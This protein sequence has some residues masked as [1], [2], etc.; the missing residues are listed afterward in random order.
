MELMGEVKLKFSQAEAV[1]EEP[2]YRTEIKKK[3]KVKCLKMNQAIGKKFGLNVGDTVLYTRLILMPGHK[4]TI[5][6]REKLAES[7]LDKPEQQV[8]V[9]DMSKC[10]IIFD[11]IDELSAWE[12]VDYDYTGE[13]NNVSEDSTVIEIMANIIRNNIANESSYMFT[14]RPIDSVNAANFDRSIRIFGFGKQEIEQCVSAICRNDTKTSQKVIDFIDRRPHL[15]LFCNIPIG[16]IMTGKVVL[17][18]VISSKR[19]GDFSMDVNCSTSLYILIVLVIL[20]SRQ[21]ERNILDKFQT[22]EENRGLLQQL[23]KLAKMNTIIDSPRLVFETEMLKQAGNDFSVLRSGFLD[24]ACADVDFLDNLGNHT[25][26]FIHY[27]IQEFLSAAYLVINWD[28]KDIT[29]VTMLRNANAFDSVLLFTAGLLGNNLG[30]KF[31]MRIDNSQTPNILD[32]RLSTF[33]S[34]TVKAYH[35]V[36]TFL[37]TLKKPPKTPKNWA[38]SA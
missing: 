17:D 33:I 18:E 31:V 11:G 9:E 2:A 30:R 21:M 23:M 3:M 4:K 28:D 12:Q 27:S 7:M 24:V 14:S 37:P 32:K 6:G 15:S 36:F 34:R 1:G 10:L 5:I 22:V 13:I 35:G 25:C 20:Q 38:T 26:S 8:K 19:T 29:F 16:C